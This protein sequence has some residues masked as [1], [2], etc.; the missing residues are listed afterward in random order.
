[1][2]DA[3]G[4]KKTS[5]PQFSDIWV[6]GSPHGSLESDFVPLSEFKLAIGLDAQA[7]MSS[8][9]AGYVGRMDI[10]VAGSDITGRA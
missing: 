2:P 8:S 3:P 5:S 4:F 7:W 1:M 6:G 9:H 10:S